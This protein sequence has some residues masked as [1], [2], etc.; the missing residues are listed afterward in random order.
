MKENRAAV[1]DLAAVPV[2]LASQ[3]VDQEIAVDLVGKRD[4][5]RNHLHAGP[6][7]VDEIRTLI[8][9]EIRFKDVVG[10]DVEPV[11][12]D[13]RSN[14][15]AEHQGAGGPD[16][17]CGLGI[18]ADAHLDGP[19]IPGSDILPDTP[20]NMFIPTHYTEIR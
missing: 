18:V 20:F 13:A 15:S 9:P 3:V 16:Q 5:R 7:G 6:H 8:Q 11:V 19:T 14:V 10:H 12:P 17:P 4:Q 1:H 2:D